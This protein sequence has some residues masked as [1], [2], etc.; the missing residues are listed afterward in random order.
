MYLFDCLPSILVV[1]YLEVE[2]LGHIV[3]LCLTFEELPHCFSQRCNHFTFPP[4]MCEGSNF[5]ISTAT[6]VLFSFFFYSSY[7]AGYECELVPHC[8]LICILMV[9]NDVHIFSCIYSP[10]VYILW[11]NVYSSSLPIFN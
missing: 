5:C 11:R 2:L 8:G 3:F 9:T 1:K 4:V 10:F 7:P 6:L